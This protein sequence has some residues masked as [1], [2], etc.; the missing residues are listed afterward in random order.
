MYHTIGSMNATLKNMLSMSRTLISSI[1]KNLQE[2]GREHSALMP[3]YISDHRRPNSSSA[4]ATMGTNTSNLPP[5]GEDNYFEEEEEERSF[6]PRDYAFN[7]SLRV[8]TTNTT[9]PAPARGSPG[10][11]SPN[12][13]RNVMRLNQQQGLSAN[14]WPTK[15]CVLHSMESIICG[16]LFVVD[17]VWVPE[18]KNT[19][20]IAKNYVNK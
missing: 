19:E 17:Y 16:E 6:D 4:L 15:R 9:A 3:D 2:F 11:R 13:N 12:R 5:S 18:K 1:E 8:D 20:L 14:S 10:R 7:Q